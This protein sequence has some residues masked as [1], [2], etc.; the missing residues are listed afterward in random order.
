MINQA[1]SSVHDTESKMTEY[2]SQLP[3]DQV[4]D[5]K[6]KITEVGHLTYPDCCIFEKR[7]TLYVKNCVWLQMPDERRS[8]TDIL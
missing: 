4:E 5:I 1:E 2:A 8:L 7:T 3:A 6:K